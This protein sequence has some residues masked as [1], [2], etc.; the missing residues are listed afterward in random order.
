MGNRILIAEDEGKLR[1]V[2]C[3][4]FRSKGDIPVEAENG[5]KALALA[6]E[7]TF[8]A[9]LLDIMMPELDGLSVCR[10][11]RRK[12]EVPIIF[13]TALSAEED[14]LLGYELGADDYV[15]K[16]FTLSVLYA[17]R[18]DGGSLRP[19]GVGGETGGPPDP[20][21]VRPPPLPDAEQKHRHEPG[22]AAGEVLGLRLRGGGPGGGHPHQAAAGEAGGLRRLH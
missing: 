10:C 4:Y 3:D 7:E 2:L 15:T 8:D 20:Q 9:V 1:E 5:A 16:P 21:G 11:L 22:A 14:K 19:A 17:K 12:Q 6:E 13:L 18:R